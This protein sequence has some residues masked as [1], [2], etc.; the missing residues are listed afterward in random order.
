MGVGNEA[1]SGRDTENQ[2]CRGPGR[3][4][5]GGQQDGAKMAESMTADQFHLRLDQLRHRLGQVRHK[6]DIGATREGEDRPELDQVDRG[7]IK[8]TREGETR[9]KLDQEDRGDMSEDEPAGLD[10]NEDKDV[11]EG[12]TGS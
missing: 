2:A 8:A 1:G 3:V 7:H 5:D 9:P 4:W 6:L 10:G 12:W 11:P